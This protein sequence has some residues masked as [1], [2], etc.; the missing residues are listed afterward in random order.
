M[1]E[2]IAAISLVSNIVQFIQ[3]GS[4]VI[5]RLNDFNSSINDVPKVFRDIRIELP[6]LLDTLQKTKKQAET[7]NVPAET[8]KALLPVVDGCCDQVEIL[9]DTLKRV[10]TTSEDS[11]WQR[12]RKA[13]TSIGVEKK[14][15][16]IIETL[17]GYVQ[18]LTYY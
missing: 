12:G 8:E 14:S 10:L 7:G 2:A 17:R 4:K 6:L 9:D 18:I 3:L 1:A 16:T 11:S 15:Q 5:S 13:L